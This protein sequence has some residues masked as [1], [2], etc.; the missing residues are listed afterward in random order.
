MAHWLVICFVGIANIQDNT[1]GQNVV[2]QED[3]QHN[4]S[5]PTT[6]H[7]CAVLLKLSIFFEVLSSLVPNKR[8]VPC[9]LGVQL[10][11]HTFWTVKNT[12]NDHMDPLKRYQDEE[13]VNAK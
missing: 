7:V 13:A 5:H 1:F 10:I 9:G 4:I 12:C 3:L 6:T 8:D 11:N 2:S